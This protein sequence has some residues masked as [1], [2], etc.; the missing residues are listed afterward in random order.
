M[1]V[2][3]CTQNDHYASMNSN[4]ISNTQELQ[5]RSRQGFKDT[6]QVNVAI[7]SSAYTYFITHLHIY[8]YTFLHFIQQKENSM[9][10]GIRSL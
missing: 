4:L 7:L 1:V 5:V 9:N 2:L 3:V 8:F 6:A 10:Y